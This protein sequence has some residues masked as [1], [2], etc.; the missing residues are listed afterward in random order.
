M[1]RFFDDRDHD[2]AN[3]ESARYIPIKLFC[4]FSQWPALSTLIFEFVGETYQ[5]LPS[6]HGKKM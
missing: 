2:E 1:A 6:V 3:E 5:R 4:F